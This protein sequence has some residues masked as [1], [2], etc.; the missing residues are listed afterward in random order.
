MGGAF[1]ALK[2]SES[3]VITAI[4]SAAALPV[5]HASSTTITLPVLRTDLRI[6]PYL[7]ETQK[8]EGLKSPL[9]RP[10]IPMPRLQLNSRAPSL[11]WQNGYI[12]TF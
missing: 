5:T 2:V 6:A 8:N 4:I 3:S 1:K 10:R 9:I 11:L 12:L 7:R